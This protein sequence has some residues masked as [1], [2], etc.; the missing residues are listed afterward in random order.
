MNWWS[1]SRKLGVHERRQKAAREARRFAKSGQVLSPV[2]IDGRT[3]ARS[4]WGKAWCENLESYGDYES[5]LPR[6][7][8][9]VR[10]GAVLD[11]KV[12]SGKIAA[13]VCGS[14]IYQVAITIKHLARGHWERIKTQ[15]AGNVGSVIELLEGRL[16]ERVMQVVTHRGEGLFP[17]PAE[18]QME[19]SCPD[20][21]TMCKHVA[22]VMYGVGARLDQQPELL[23]GLRNVD[24]AELI[25]KA[26]DLASNR[27]A[28]S[29][30]VLAEDVLGDVFGIEI[31]SASPKKP[32]VPAKTRVRKP[33]PTAA[34]KRVGRT[35]RKSKR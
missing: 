29:R 16:S 24:H 23:F 30:K 28:S 10:S 14:E 11:L 15:C 17:K 21:A 9:Y 31:G 6:G 34:R 18:I 35:V 22:A 2:A 27:K 5:R 12:T 33:E 8:S 7:R 25:V 19:C 20:W 32:P 26:V 3:I 1:Y 13:L 4:F